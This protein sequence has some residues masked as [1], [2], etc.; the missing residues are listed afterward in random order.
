[1]YL[2]FARPERV[3]FMYSK[4]VDTYVDAGLRVNVNARV[5]VKGC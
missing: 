1:V 3:E 4:Q 2:E 5:K